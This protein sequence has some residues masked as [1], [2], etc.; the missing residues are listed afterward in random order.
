MQFIKFKNA[1]EYE[2]KQLI[3]F[4]QQLTST[5]N[6][7]SIFSDHQSKISTIFPFAHVDGD[8]GV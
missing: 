3:G 2:T 1:S 4:F 6:L 7:V 8:S 5:P